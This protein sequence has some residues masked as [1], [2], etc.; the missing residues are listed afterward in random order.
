[1]N[2]LKGQRIR[3]KASAGNAVDLENWF[4]ID[5]IHRIYQQ[6]PVPNR[7][8]KLEEVYLLAAPAGKPIR[9]VRLDRKLANG[10]VDLFDVTRQE[11]L[12]VDLGDDYQLHKYYPDAVIPSVTTDL[13]ITSGHTRPSNFNTNTTPSYRFFS[14]RGSNTNLSNFQSMGGG[15][16]FCS[17]R[18]TKRL[19]AR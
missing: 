18:K 8:L 1:M 2:T 6:A 5:K 9:L 15:V 14:N 7:L 16:R 10:R 12:T 4:N 11:T 13:N 17:K 3:A 19:K